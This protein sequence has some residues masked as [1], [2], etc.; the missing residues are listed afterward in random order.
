[1]GP[2]RLL[3]RDERFRRHPGARRRSRAIPR[4]SSPRRPECSPSAATEGI[5][6]GPPARAFPA[7]KAIPRPSR[8]PGDGGATFLPFGQSFGN[9]TLERLELD[10]SGDYLSVINRGVFRYDP[11]TARFKPIGRR[12]PAQRFYGLFTLDPH[13]PGRL[14]AAVDGVGLK[15]LDLV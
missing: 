14:Y 10:A 12:L 15:R 7:S 13:H 1:P 11:A 4:C 2:R 8:E 9:D 3:D 5:T 6:G